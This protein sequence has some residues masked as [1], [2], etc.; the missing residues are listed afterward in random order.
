MRSRSMPR[1]RPGLLLV[2]LAF[3]APLAAQLPLRHAPRHTARAISAAD[4]M[5]RL[6]IYA[7]DSMQGR[8]T[9]TAGHVRSTAYIERELRSLGLEPAGDSGGFFQNVPMLRRTFDPA[10]S[11][12]VAGTM[13]RGGEDFIATSRGAVRQIDGV[14]VVFG[15][16]AFDTTNL[17]T[18]DQVRGRIVVVR[19]P[20]GRAGFAAAAG[21]GGGGGARA[22]AIRPYTES[23]SGAAAIATL[24]DSLTATQVDSATRPREGNVFVND[25][26]TGAPLTLTV[27]ASAAEAL[28]GAPADGAVKGQAGR[29]VQANI[30]FHDEAAPGRNLVAI[31]GGSD[32]RLRGQFVALGAHNDHIGLSAGAPVDHD[33]LHLYNQARFAIV[34]MVPRGRR[35]SPEQLA[36]VAAIR[37]NM[38]SVR[39][40]R[41][42]RPDSIRNGADD[43]GSGSVTLLELAEAFSRGARPKRSILFVW[44]TG[45]EKGLLGSRWF[46]DHPTVPR[47]SIVAQLNLDMV[48]RGDARDLPVGGPAYLQL[49]GSR[50]LSTELGD[51]VETVNRSERQPFQFDYQFDANGHPDNIYCRSDHY[52]YARYGIPVVFFTTGQHGDYHQVTDEPQ[53]V[54]YDHMARVGR[55]VYDVA[56]RVA[57]LDH[58]PLVDHA[59]P[60]PTAACR[61]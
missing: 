15:G 36:Q 60:D 52:S 46:A 39:Q 41:A 22:A 14:Q 59:K 45:E 32:P 44:H 19:A 27:T 48:G 17:L 10:S 38:D 49:V 1:L 29:S 4:L 8:E 57:N 16:M 55:L 24:V 18:P 5:T 51:L 56:L 43:D 33:S 9:G 2:L 26:R 6:Y 20:R 34:G 37:V 58:R 61:Q 23:L 53:Y 47:D 28:L 11:I 12:T 42:T 40:Q 35:A 3:P 30:V 50:R 31:L 54:D 21:G 25:G 7:D 13:L